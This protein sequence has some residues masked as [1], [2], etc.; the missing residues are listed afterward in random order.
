MLLEQAV[1]RAFGALK[2][3]KVLKHV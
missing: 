1:S 2:M 3:N